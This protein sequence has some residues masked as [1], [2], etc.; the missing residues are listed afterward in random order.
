MAVTG[1]LAFAVVAGVGAFVASHR[2]LVAAVAWCVA[3][4]V[5]ARLLRMLRMR[6]LRQH[7]ARRPEDASRLAA[8]AWAKASPGQRAA[9][10]MFVKK[11]P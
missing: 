2:L 11:S 1:G 4:P 6:R 10:Q 9:L 7:F 5:A 3:F 8:A